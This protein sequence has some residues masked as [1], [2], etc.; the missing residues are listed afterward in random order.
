MSKTLYVIS[1][2]V[3]KNMFCFPF[4]FQEHVNTWTCPETQGHHVLQF[5]TFLAPCDGTR[6]TVRKEC[7]VLADHTS[8]FLWKRVP[9]LMDT[10]SCTSAFVGQWTSSFCSGS[11]R[12]DQRTQSKVRETDLHCNGAPLVH[13]ALS[14]LQSN[15]WS[16]L[17]GPLSSPRWHI[18]VIFLEYTVLSSLSS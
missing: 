1:F 6:Y 5:I 12:G 10:N 18:A 4:V 15:W 8:G 2:G 14:D 13:V 16:G 9:R 7:V 3:K 11:R 17:K